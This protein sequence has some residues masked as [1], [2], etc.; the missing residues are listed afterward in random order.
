[1]D[2]LD[3]AGVVAL[4]VVLAWLFQNAH[5]AR[6]PEDRDGEGPWCVAAVAFADLDGA[7]VAA[8]VACVWLLGVVR[9][10][11]PREWRDTVVLGKGQIVTSKEDRHAHRLR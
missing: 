9:S 10:D 8:L 11:R 4:A 5:R 6:R 3:L 1:M 7:L 2:W